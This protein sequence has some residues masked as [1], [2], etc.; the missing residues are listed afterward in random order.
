M[1]DR[2]DWMDTIEAEHQAKSWAERHGFVLV[3]REAFARIAEGKAVIVERDEHGTP[4]VFR[5]K[6]GGDE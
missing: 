1:S 6:R 2:V 3:N 5:D 4:T